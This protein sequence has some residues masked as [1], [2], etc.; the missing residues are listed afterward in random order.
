VL[1]AGLLAACAPDLTKPEGALGEL[2]QGCARG[3]SVALFPALDQRSR[4]ALD[5]IA[6]ARHK[7]QGVIVGSY[8]ADAQQEALAQLGDARDTKTGAELF[9]RRCDPACFEALCR[10]ISAPAS[11]E[12]TGPEARVRTLRG[13][14]LTLYREHEHY[15]LVWNTEAL[16]RERKRAFA[17]L[18]TIEAN[19]KVYAQQK[20]LQ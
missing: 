20:T 5:A 4:F 1:T 11:V 8:P 13:A 12:L 17:E 10:G 15:G 9:G 3:E 14:E 6:Q 18:S 2:A 7:A 16:L 19:A